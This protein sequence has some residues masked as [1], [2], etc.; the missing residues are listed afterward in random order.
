MASYSPSPNSVPA[1]E[2]SSINI[3]SYLLAT[4]GSLLKSRDT[5]SLNFEAAKSKKKTSSGTSRDALSGVFVF[6]MSKAREQLLLAIAQLSSD[7]A[8]SVFFPFVLACFYSSFACHAQEKEV[9]R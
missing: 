2:P 9:P 7:L 6:S 8:T 1:R 5:R 3:P 4:S